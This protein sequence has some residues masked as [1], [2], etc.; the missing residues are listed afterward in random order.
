MSN[1]TTEESISAILKKVMDLSLKRKQ[2]LDV[3]ERIASKLGTLKEKELPE[4]ELLIAE[5]QK[6]KSEFFELIK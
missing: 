4:Y 2:T 3:I 1:I 6:L 5:Y